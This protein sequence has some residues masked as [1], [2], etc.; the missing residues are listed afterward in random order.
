MRGEIRPLQ[1]SEVLA[2]MP[3]DARPVGNADHGRKVKGKPKVRQR[4]RMLNTFVDRT[5]ATILRSD[6]LV[7]IVL[8]RDARGDT[9]RVAQAY[10]ANRAGLCRRTVGTAIKRLE[11]A[12]L[13]DVVYR[14]GLNCGLSVYRIR[15]ERIDG[16][17]ADELHPDM[18]N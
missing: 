5:M 16:T 15:A 1:G 18:R 17:G 11:R 4:F 7:W 3:T 12:G 2:P 14:G 8:F 6:A 13:L 9:T 10:I